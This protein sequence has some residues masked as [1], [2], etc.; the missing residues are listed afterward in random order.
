MITRVGAPGSGSPEVADVGAAED[1][2]GLVADLDA[3]RHLD[4][5]AAEA[6]EPGDLHH[7]AS[8]T[9]SRR[10]RSMPPNR[11]RDWVFAPDPPLARAGDAAED[12]DVPVGSASVAPAVSMV[13]STRPGGGAGRRGVGA[14]VDQVAGDRDQVVE[15]LGPHQLV[16][17]LVVLVPGQPALG[18][19]GAQHGGHLVA[20]GVGRAQVAS[21][22]GAD[23]GGFGDAVGH[24]LHASPRARRAARPMGAIQGRPGEVQ[25]PP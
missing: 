2:G 19:R 16:E 20:V 22:D 11:A 9:A 24:E 3:L 23:V 12:R 14:L 6:P 1:A 21:G 7:G 8:K 17:P 4:V 15:G 18:V 25:G 13:K 10:S 5:Q